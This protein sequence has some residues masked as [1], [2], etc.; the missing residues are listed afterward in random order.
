MFVEGWRLAR[1][2]VLLA[3]LCAGWRCGLEQLSQCAITLKKSGVVLVPL[4]EL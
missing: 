1:R 3:V 2:F 4:C